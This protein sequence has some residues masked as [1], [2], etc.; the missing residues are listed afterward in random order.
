MTNVSFPRVFLLLT[1]AL[2]LSV[3]V[4]AETPSPSFIR[5][6]TVSCQSSG[7]EWG[8]PEFGQALDRLKVLGITHVAIHPYA[9]VQ[10]EGGVRFRP[11]EQQGNLVRA[12]AMAKERGVGLMLIPHLAYWG[13]KFKWRGS[14][15][16]DQPAQWEKFFG[17]YEEWITGL[18]KLAQEGGA[19][20]FCVGHEYDQMTHFD[21]RW[22]HII[23]E[24][25]KV[26]SGRVTYHANWTEYQKITFWDAV[27][28][29]GI[30]AY[31]ILSDKPDP[32]PADLDAAWK[33]LVAEIG[34]FAK[35]K[36]KRVIFTEIGYNESS[37]AAAKPWEYE[38]GG[39][40]AREIRQRAT[41][42]ALR[43]EGPRFPELEGVFFWK[44]FPDMPVER[45]LRFIPLLGR[46]ARENFDM[47]DE[48]MVD[49]L[50]QAWGS[51]VPLR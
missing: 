12:M 51:K 33:N 32:T 34:A 44:W 22:R 11:M 14:I 48:Y 7:Y 6:M 49:A 31:F 13:T 24:V 2:L 42:A 50:R 16:Y 8:T 18:A 38:M 37:L 41:E 35:S 19:E 4:G 5:G 45:R 39:P 9:Q 29:M 36:G 25:R 1:S 30:G 21:A 3:R 17:D 15:W 10:N 43:L 26:Y 28:V 47:R 23:A 40:N 46:F 20:L 27:D